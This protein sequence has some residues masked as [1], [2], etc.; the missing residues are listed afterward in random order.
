MIIDLKTLEL[1]INKELENVCDWLLANKLTLNTKKSN[2][3]LFHPRQRATAIHL[4]I[5]VFDCEHNV[6]EHLEQKDCVKYLGVLIDSNLS[7]QDHINYISLK[8]NKTIG[9]I[10]RLRYVLP[11]SILLHIYRSL[12][13]P[14]ISYGLSVWGQTSKLNLEKILILQKRALRLF[15]FRNN[16]E[17]AIPL[18]V[19]SNILPV[20]MLYF[21]SIASLMHDIN[22]QSA[23]LNLI[24]LFDRVDSVHSYRTRSASTGKCHIKCS[25]L[26]Q[27][28][29]SFLTRELRMRDTSY[30]EQW[31]NVSL[32]RSIRCKLYANE[33]RARL[34]IKLLS[35]LN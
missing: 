24:N 8:I 10:S 6:F 17:H 34:S 20:D 28:S 35:N 12:I 1:I 7:W 29:H 23:P 2:Y 4:H 19:Y 22:N 30:R 13:H 16:R 25:K 3:V 9:I 14:Y 15:Y 32:D 26:T 27:L 5:K 11:T 31:E 33:V 18:Y 21:K